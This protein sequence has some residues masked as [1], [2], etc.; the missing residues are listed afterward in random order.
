MGRTDNATEEEQMCKGIDVII[1]FFHLCHKPDV[2]VTEQGDGWP[3]FS[4]STAL[5]SHDDLRKHKLVLSDSP[6][7]RS[8]EETYNPPFFF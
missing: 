7:R 2:A 3:V 4:C 8:L 6:S 1:V 5:I